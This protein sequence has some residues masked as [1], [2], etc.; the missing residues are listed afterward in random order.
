MDRARKG[1]TRA[2]DEL[3]RRHHA[4]VYRTA[5]G[6]LHDEDRAQDAAQ[7][8]FLKALRGLETFRGDAAF[9]TWLVTIAV[10]EARASLRRTGRRV[11]MPLEESALPGNPGPDP[12]EQAVTGS[13][14]GRIRACLATLPEKQRL[15]VSLRIFE[16]MSF[17]EVGE[18]IG[19]SEGAARVNY[20]HGIRRLRELVG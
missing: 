2:M 18:A 14:V 6:I 1:D 7:E 4:T 3:V 9:K 12:S 19:S 5:L 17:R 15:A 16:G 10:N 11:E 20:H 13:E 8:T